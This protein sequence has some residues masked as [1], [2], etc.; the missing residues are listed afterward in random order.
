MRDE[1][2]GK[3]ETWHLSV[4]LREDKGV[5][6]E[7]KRLLFLPRASHWAMWLI[8]STKVVIRQCQQMDSEMRKGYGEPCFC[9]FMTQTGGLEDG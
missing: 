8:P 9:M 2:K 4:P 6:E 5:K 1:N 7:K 3:I